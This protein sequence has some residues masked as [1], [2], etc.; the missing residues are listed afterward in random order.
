[1]V[2]AVVLRCLAKKSIA[3][4]ISFL[5]LVHCNKSAPGSIKRRRQMPKKT[6]P[7][8]RPRGRPVSGRPPKR[9]TTMRLAPDVADYLD[10][11][12]KK[13]ETVEAAVRLTDGYK[14]QLKEKR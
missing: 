8:K 14:R 7:P 13:A 6:E 4:I 10:T 1:M 9:N 5:D 3:K 11:V 12:A 2:L